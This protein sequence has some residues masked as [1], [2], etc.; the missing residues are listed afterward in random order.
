MPI[1][2][3]YIFLILF[4]I[5]LIIFH[6]FYHFPY[7]IID[8]FFQSFPNNKQLKRAKIYDKLLYLSKFNFSYAF[9]H[10]KV[11]DMPDVTIM[12]EF[13]INNDIGYFVV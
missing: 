9:D 12:L 1:I 7:N 11:K 2:P 3:T 8:S 4:D 10:N 5:L 13:N 6:I